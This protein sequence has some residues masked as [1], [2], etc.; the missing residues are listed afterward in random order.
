MSGH[1]EP[2]WQAFVRSGKFGF[3]HAV[4]RPAATATPDTSDSSAC[5]AYTALNAAHHH[6]R[7]P[8]EHAPGSFSGTERQYASARVR[9]H[10]VWRG[11]HSHIEW[12]E[13]RVEVSHVDWQVSR[14]QIKL[15]SSNDRVS[16]TAPL[17][18]H[19]K[20]IPSSLEGHVSGTAHGSTTLTIRPDFNL[21]PTVDLAVDL[22][23]ADVAG[24]NIKGLAQGK[25][26]EALKG[27]KGKVSGAV[28]KAVNLRGIA[29]KAWLGLPGSVRVPGQQSI[30]LTIDPKAIMLEGPRAAGG[31]ITA[32]LSLQA[33]LET[34]I[35]SGPPSQPPRHPLPNLASTPTDQ[36]FHIDLPVVAQI[37]ELNRLLSSVLADHSTIKLGEG[38]AVSLK[39]ALVFPRGNRLYL[40]VSFEGTRGFWLR[41]MKGTLVCGVIPHLDA[42]KQQLSFERVDFTA[43][44]RSAV[45][46]SAVWLAEPVIARELQKRLVVNIGPQLHNGVVEANKM[47]SRITLPAPLHLD[48]KLEKLEAETIGVFGNLL[49]IEFEASGTARL[50]H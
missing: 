8:N 40:K 47:A 44:T 42:T 34:F 2:R 20:L 19:A 28:A 3:D 17:H 22:D 24:I 32:T 23:H 39:G 21:D 26:N 31:T 1:F 29:E 33:R 38:N 46:Q 30:W 49:Y 16:T 11:I 13:V 41:K 10:P 50:P 43:Q 14:G 48:L 37:A 35:Q 7:L 12:D 5:P 25:A 27:V 6:V 36:H 15:G 9:P 18:G 4:R 45:S